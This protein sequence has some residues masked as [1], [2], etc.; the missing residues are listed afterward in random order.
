MCLVN[1]LRARCFQA[2]LEIGKRL[3][4]GARGLARRGAVRGANALDEPREQALDCA[5]RSERE[6]RG[7]MPDM[8]PH[9][10]SFL[11]REGGEV[12]TR[13]N[14][15]NARDAPIEALTRGR[16]HAGA[17]PRLVPREREESEEEPERGED[18]YEM[19]HG[20]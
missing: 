12:Y 17:A 3:H 15:L 4:E 13:E 5:H 6:V 16:E 8:A 18:E 2:V 1:I 19:R 10:S 7:V 14:E 20:V 9:A 11:A